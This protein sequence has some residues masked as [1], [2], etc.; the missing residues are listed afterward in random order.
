MLRRS[1]RLVFTPGRVRVPRGAP[2]IPPTAIPRLVGRC[3]GRD[4]AARQPPCSGSRR[5]A[6]LTGSR[7]CASASRKPGC[8]S[9]RHDDGTPARVRRRRSSTPASAATATTSTP[10]GRRSLDIC[11]GE[12]LR[13]DLGPHPLLRPLADAPALAAPVQHPL[14]RRRHAAPTSARSTTTASRRRALDPPGGRARPLARRARADPADAR[15]PRRVHR[16]RRRPA[17][18]ST[19]SRR[20]DGSP[21]RSR[22]WAPTAGCARA[23][24]RR[25]R[26]GPRRAASARRRAAMA[27]AERTRQAFRAAVAPQPPRNG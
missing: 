4:D 18:C 1:H 3:W 16:L 17:S 11:A 19:R 6:R 2:S 14:L 23:A 7:P 15:V 5:R 13:L 9:P 12:H 27:D 8:C 26:D 10:A 25:S 20:W 21:M 22:G 24:A